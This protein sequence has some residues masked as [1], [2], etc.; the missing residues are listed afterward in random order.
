MTKIDRS[1]CP[2]RQ[3]NDRGYAKCTNKLAG[4]WFE[5]D[6]LEYYKNE[7][8]DHIEDEEC[9]WVMNER[10]KR[11]EIMLEELSGQNR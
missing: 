9:P 7:S 5:Y 4:L 3:E 2:Y 1:K 11:L 8:C 10:I 6:S